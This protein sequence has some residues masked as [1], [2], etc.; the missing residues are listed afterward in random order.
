M[1]QWNMSVDQW[2]M[3]MDQQLEHILNQQKMFVD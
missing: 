2:N 3:F 1:D